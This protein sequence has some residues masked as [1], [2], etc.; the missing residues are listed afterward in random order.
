[1]T[2]KIIAISDGDTAT[3]LS[4]KNEQVKIRLSQID[5]PELSGQAF[6]EKSKKSLSEQIYG[7]EV[8]V[9]V[10]TK[11]HFGRTVGK[12]LVGGVDANLVQVQRGMAWFYAQYGREVAYRNAEAKAKTERVGLWSEPNPV[13]PWDFRHGSKSSAAK[14][15]TVPA[16]NS[17]ASCGS[18][19][20]CKEMSS[21]DEATMY[22]KQCGVSTLDGNHDGVPCEKLCK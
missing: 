14:E 6:G 15:P 9:E 4:S 18:K 17:I 20:T 11:D 8:T 16:K 1:L 5:A 19:R 2:G 3:L 12:I 22:L 13:P 10:E 7:K 21:C